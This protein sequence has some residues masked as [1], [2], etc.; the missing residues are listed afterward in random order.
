MK[1]IPCVHVLKFQHFLRENCV[2]SLTQGCFRGA[3]DWWPVCAS[4]W[5]PLAAACS[6][7]CLGLR[8]SARGP[9]PP[10]PSSAG[11]ALSLALL[12]LPL[13]W[14]SFP[15]APCSCWLWALRFFFT[16]LYILTD[17]SAFS[18]GQIVLCLEKYSYC[19]F[20][21]TEPSRVKCSLDA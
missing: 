15:P 14:P 2:F 11:G 19:M 9:A 17:K 4:G 20:Y 3:D 13:L 1:K 21:S 18:Y 7:G 16:A 10:E 12:S 8:P 6:G 5:Q